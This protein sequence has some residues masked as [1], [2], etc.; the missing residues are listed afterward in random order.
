MEKK[1]KGKEKQVKS[2]K[3]RRRFQNERAMPLAMRCEYE[4][5]NDVLLFLQVET[6][7][8]EEEEES[9]FALTIR[10]PCDPKG[11]DPVGSQGRLAALD[12]TADVHC[13][14]MVDEN[15]PHFPSQVLYSPC[16]EKE[17]GELL[18]QPPTKCLH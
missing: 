15:P 1:K 18:H 3:V 6:F 10:V 12:S 17:V 14:H 11:G 4:Q 7:I 13:Q 2:G 8:L 16:Q 9:G 5:K